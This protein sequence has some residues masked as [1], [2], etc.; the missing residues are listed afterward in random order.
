MTIAVPAVVRAADS[1]AVAA[2]SVTAAGAPEGADPATA[3][4]AEEEDN[5]DVGLF[6][7]QAKTFGVVWVPLV[8]YRSID[9]YGAGLEALL[10]MSLDPSGLSR[11]SD[12]R[13]SFYYTGN[14]HKRF[15]GETNLFWGRGRYLARA[16]FQY[17]D[18]AQ[19]FWGIGADNDGISEVY[20]PRESQL[21]GEFFRSIG[22]TLRLGLRAEYVSWRLISFEQGG[23]FAS[24]QVPG[25]DFSEAVGG[26]F[27][28]D[29]DTRD[30]RF[31]PTSGFH[32]QGFA[33]FFTDEFGGD[34]EY[35][36]Y[37]LEWRG[38]HGLGGEHVLASQAFFYSALGDPPFWRLAELGGRH[39]SRGYRRGRY[40]D[41]TMVAAQLEWRFPLAGKL[42]GVFFGGA[43]T[44]ADR[45]E[46]LESRFLRPT[47]GAGLRLAVGSGEESI[48]I[49]G[50]VAVG[51]DSV[52]WYLGVGDAF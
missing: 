37:N 28:L 40:R 30:R 12:V 16:R 18:L 4:V 29:W 34:Y 35:N 14:R 32:V 36:T 5:L 50:D 31:Q 51:Q 10:P 6:P 39:H 2:D 11:Q 46:S 8:G 27:L 20:R 33:L 38:Y 47:I 48:P 24:G 22:R 17:S 3:T 7:P 26:G 45:L 43:A 21:Y 44:V 25:Q 1:R 41:N 9:G 19:R 49:R 42:K 23:E 15:N 52:E 13:G